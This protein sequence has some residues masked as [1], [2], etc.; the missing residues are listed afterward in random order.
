MSTQVHS[1]EEPKSTFQK[2]SYIIYFFAF[3]VIMTAWVIASFV[4]HPELPA[5]R[6]CLYVFVTLKL[7]FDIVGVSFVTKPIG[8]VAGVV[9]SIFS[10][11]SETV[12]TIAG[13][14]LTLLLML[15][16]TFLSPTDENGT[17]IQRAQSLFGVLIIIF[18]LYA[19]SANRRA[20]KWRTVVLGIFLQ[21]VLGI[22]VLKSQVGYEIFKWLS[23]IFTKLVGYSTEG[24]SFVLNKDIASVKI[25]LLSAL[26]G[27]IFIAALVQ[28]C[29][30]LG[31]M[32][33]VILKFAW[34]MAYTLDTSGCESV[35]AAAS[36]FV[37]Q[38][39]SA[40]LVKPFIENMTKSE[41]H[42]VMASGFATISGSIM[43]AFISLGVDGQTLITS[44]IMSVPCSL[45]LS[46]LRYPETEVSESYGKVTIPQQE[47]AEVNILHAAANG[48][49]QGIHLVLLIVASIVA[50]ISLISAVDALIGWIGDVIDI[51]GLSLSL[52]IGYI[53]YPV[54]WCIGIEGKECLYV[55]QL[56]ARKMM[57]NEFAAFTALKELKDAGTL[58][59]RSNSIA[60]FSLC[61]FANFGSIGIQIGCLGAMA[62]RR[63][64]DLASLAFSAM[65]TG[66]FST[67]ISAAIAGLLL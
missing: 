43:M 36:P 3:W 47:N 44:C 25:F 51:Q 11:F 17:L 66:T 65:I 12:L 39:E 52:I 31:V 30:Y 62:P 4:L 57:V 9:S 14:V 8:S 34:L 61:G 15:L 10:R 46:K 63:Q 7:L 37:G 13:A 5:V 67:L 45:A 38:G 21:Y 56:L 41:L 40:L 42:Q 20:V 18:V 50:V 16:V 26:P 1:E 35:V 6:A 48:A 19:T 49:A 28:I 2:H 32:Q 53:F 22:F 60:T 29:Y 64:G 58:S 55:G 33:W 27:I 24:M 54:A 59:I 23:E